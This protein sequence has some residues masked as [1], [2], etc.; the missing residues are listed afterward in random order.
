MATPIELKDDVIGI[1]PETTEGTFVAPS[2][3]TSYVR[4]LE[5]GLALSPQRE[6]LERTLLTGDLG[7]IKPCKGMKSSSATVGIEMRGSGVEGGQP[8][9][10]ELL[11]NALGGNREVSATTTSTTSNTSTVI[12]MSDGDAADFTLGDVVVVKESGAYEARP[13]SAIS[14]TGGSNS[15]T[16]PFALDNGAPSDSVVVSKTQMYY[17]TNSGHT[18]LSLARYIGNEKRYS[19]T[20]MKV[21]S[22]SVE[23]FAAGQLATMTFELVGLGY[24]L[25]DGAASHTPTYDSVA[26]IC[27]IDLYVYREGT[28]TPCQSFTL[29]LSN[30]INEMTDVTSANGKSGLVMGRPREI[31][32]TI[33]PYMDDASTD[34]FDDWDSNTEFSVF[35]YGYVPSSTSGEFVAGSV[36]SF[37]LPN[38]I[39]TEAGQGQTNQLHTDEITFK[40]LADEAGTDAE[41]Y[42]GII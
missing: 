34:V 25:A 8:D 32:G 41:L 27:G 42:I 17:T 11:K 1:E 18:S 10:H 39:I 7:N 35:A 15:I 16:F 24:G 36:V 37:W 21:Q 13:V 12:N 30:T 33:N 28:A 31:T 14:T 6:V 5:D 3:A 19:G 2:A 29:S 23:N 20:G 26:P 22:M 4:V 38:C 9:H 40:A